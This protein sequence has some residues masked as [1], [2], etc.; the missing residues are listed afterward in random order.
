MV[1]ADQTLPLYNLLRPYPHVSFLPMRILSLILCMA[2]TLSANANIDTPDLRLPDIGDPAGKVISANEEYVLGQKLLRDIQ[3]QLP[4]I[5]DL[6]LNYYLENL[7][8]RLLASATGQQFPFSFIIIRDPN[9]N[10][11]AAPG[12]I[13][14]INTGLIE[15]ASTESELAAVLAHEIAHV[16]QR[17]LARFFQQSSKINLG[18]T[19]GILAAILA[20]AYA[21]SAGQ[22]ALYAGLA[23]NSSAKLGFT[24]AHEREADR[25]GT[26]ILS[27]S[28]FD[29]QAMTTFFEKLQ[30]ETFSDPDKA[31]EFLQ[32][33]PLPGARAADRFDPLH[34]QRKGDLDSLQFQIFKA[35]SRG[36][37]HPAA[38]LTSRTIAS[39]DQRYYSKAVSLAH[40][41]QPAAALKWLDKLSP[42][43]KR[44]PQIQLL[45]A[46]SDQQQAHQGKNT[47]IIEKLFRNA[48]DN[49]TFLAAITH[50]YL[51][52]KA[53][54]RALQLL[55]ENTRLVDHWLPLLKLKA[56]AAEKSG[57]QAISHEAL[58]KYYASQGSLSLAL[59]QIDIA[60]HHP[61]TTLVIK[62]RLDELK[63]KLEALQHED[64]IN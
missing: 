39:A 23:A 16:T 57:H 19:L 4:V 41:H 46:T 45:A 10:A 12:G 5:N 61:N 1:E 36:L 14:A 58:A 33:H 17:H 30:A 21:P 47:A 15:T 29:T 32:T 56:D 63:S 44:A 38:T 13:V 53:Y 37:T 22:A 6:E 34:Y 35:R 27:R 60:E 49:P 3:H 50:R 42:R 9:I 25:I 48:P 20:S 54:G 26:S 11:F 28:G 59:E 31:N 55:S 43:W 51:T 2:L 62:A 8:T 7:G 24:R 40:N 52:M 18:T 64:T